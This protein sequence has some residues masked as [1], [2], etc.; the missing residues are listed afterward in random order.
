MINQ[1][2]NGISSMKCSGSH[3][4]PRIFERQDESLSSPSKQLSSK[5][6][7]I[8]NNKKI[9]SHG[10]VPNS[11]W[12]PSDLSKAP[13]AMENIRKPCLLQRKLLYPTYFRSKGEE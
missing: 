11:Y 5:I 7:I 1:N 6:I 13:P 12:E 8:I 3:L 2:P 9:Q 10:E 4:G